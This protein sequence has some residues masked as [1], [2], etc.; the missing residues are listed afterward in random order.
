[1]QEKPV[2]LIYFP[3]GQH[4]HQVPLERLE[5]QQGDIDWF[6]FWLKNEEDLDPGKRPQYQ[7]WEAMRSGTEYRANMTQ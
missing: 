1:L 5:S 7:R 3:M 2:D 4:I 6:R